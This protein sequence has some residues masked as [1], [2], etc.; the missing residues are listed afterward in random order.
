MALDVS[1]NFP[2]KNVSD[3]KNIS[4]CASVDADV[5][6][7]SPKKQNIM[8]HREITVAKM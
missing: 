5:V 4:M 6:V 3:S 8:A 2:L 7:Y 1:D